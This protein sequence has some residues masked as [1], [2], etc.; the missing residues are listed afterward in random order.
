MSAAATVAFFEVRGIP[1]PQGTARAFVAGGRARIATDSNRTNSP[2]G[3]W[4][5]A[6]RT[7]GQRVMGNHPPASGPVSVSVTFWMPRPKSHFGRHGLKEA[8]PDNHTNKPD[9]DKLLRAV[10]DGLTGVVIGDDSQVSAIESGKVYNE[11]TGCMVHV[12]R[13]AA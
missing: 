7:E 6:I 5:A 1:V 10:L 8:A 3:A 4:R 13:L 12:V 2:I 9:L 11:I